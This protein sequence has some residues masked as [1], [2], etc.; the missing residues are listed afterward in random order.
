MANTGMN[1]GVSQ[2]GG[3]AIGVSQGYAST[4]PDTGNIKKF[5]G[6]AWSNV[7]KIGGVAVANIKKVSG[8]SA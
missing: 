1:I 8:V 4:P 2:E 5:G 7:K 6:V 3:M